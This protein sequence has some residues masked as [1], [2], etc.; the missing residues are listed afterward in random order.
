LKRDSA[1]DP[2]R[3]AALE[4]AMAKVDAHADKKNVAQ[5]KLM[6]ANLDKTAVS[7]KT[8]VDAK[9]MKALAEVIEKSAGARL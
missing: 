2:K 3:I 8:P 4:E 9:R 6:A 7:A 5:L 1:L